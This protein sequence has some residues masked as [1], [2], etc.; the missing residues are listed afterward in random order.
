LPYTI[1]EYLSGEILTGKTSTDSPEFDEAEADVKAR[2][3]KF[4]NNGGSKPVDYFS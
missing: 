4:T 1:G 3:N 2:L